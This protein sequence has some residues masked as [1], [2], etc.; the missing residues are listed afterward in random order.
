MTG[1]RLIGRSTNPDTSMKKIGMADYIAC[2]R[3]NRFPVRNAARFRVWIGTVYGIDVIDE[4]QEDDKPAF[5]VG[6]YGSIPD[7]R[8]EDNELMEI[9]FIAEL[10]GHLPEGEQAIITEVGHEELRYLVG[11]SVAV[12]HSGSRIEVNV[13]DILD[14]TV[15]KRAARSSDIAL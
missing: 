5:E 1:E 8:D 14:Q 7:L 9:D 12:D 3:T 6:G 11:F 15:G 2:F 4:H 10:A 13:D